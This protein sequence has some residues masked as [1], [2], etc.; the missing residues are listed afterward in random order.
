[1][2]FIIDE[3]EI[4]DE[5]YSG[6]SDCSDTESLLDDDFLDKVLELDEKIKNR[7]DICCIC[8]FSMDYRALNGYFE[9]ICKAEHLFLE[10]LY[11]TEDMYRMGI[12]DFDIFFNKVTKILDNVDE[13]CESVE[14][15]HWNSF[16]T[17]SRKNDNAEIENLIGQIRKAKIHKNDASIACTKKK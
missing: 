13:F 17:I 2:D 16:S 12:L 7:P 11:G 5:I 6:N 9:D 3:A 8:G 15:E 14:R 1:M 10:G 4:S